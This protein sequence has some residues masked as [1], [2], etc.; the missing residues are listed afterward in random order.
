[1]L[2]WASLWGSR[3]QYGERTPPFV[4][5]LFGFLR[6]PTSWQIS[7][8]FSSII[9][10]TIKIQLNACNFICQTVKLMFCQ[11]NTDLFHQPT[12]SLGGHTSRADRGQTPFS[13]RLNTKIKN[14][15]MNFTMFLPF[16]S[17][18]V[19]RINFKII[20][21]VNEKLIFY[22]YCIVKCVCSSYIYNFC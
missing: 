15:L 17:S 4:T 16:L 2:Y 3:S 10:H 7:Q 18:I 6:P 8:V 20:L 1:M 12:A 19:Q 14:D 22:I 5:F 11:R 9:I 13:W 21:I